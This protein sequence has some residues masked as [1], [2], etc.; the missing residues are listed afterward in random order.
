MGF[1]EPPP[2]RQYCI[3]KCYPYRSSRR[4]FQRKTAT[5]SIAAR[6]VQVVENPHLR[7]FSPQ[8]ASR[9]GF[10]ASLLGGSNPPFVTA[11]II[12][13]SAIPR[14]PS[15]IPSRFLAFPAVALASRQLLRH[16][17]R[18][19]IGGGGRTPG[20]RRQGVGEDRGGWPGFEQGLPGYLGSSAYDN[21]FSVELTVG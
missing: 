18:R 3:Q 2:F 15:G 1:K 8:R 6:V 9:G 7:L 12:R 5:I 17:L 13:S 21:R 20:W 14:R 11:S 4:T 10:S 16:R 19:R